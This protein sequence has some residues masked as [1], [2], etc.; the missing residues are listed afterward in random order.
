[1]SNTYALVRDLITELEDVKERLVLCQESLNAATVAHSE[2]SK[3][4]VEWQRKYMEVKNQLDE[5]IAVRA[6]PRKK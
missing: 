5:L 3:T 4:V 1:M 6:K 2:A